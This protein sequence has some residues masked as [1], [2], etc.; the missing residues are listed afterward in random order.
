MQSENL[1]QFYYQNNMLELQINYSGEAE[2]EKAYKIAQ[3]KL[4][5]WKVCTQIMCKKSKNH[6]KLA[7]MPKIAQRFKRN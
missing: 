4:W 7:K 2:M 5:A 1:Y 3:A 6:A